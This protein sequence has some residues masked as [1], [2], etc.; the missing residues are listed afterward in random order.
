MKKEDQKNHIDYTPFKTHNGQGP[1]ELREPVPGY[2][3]RPGDAVLTPTKFGGVD[4]NSIIIFGRDRD[5]FRET[6]DG[7][8]EK[9][10]NDLFSIETVSGYSDYMGAGSI[11]IVVG[12]GAP[13]AVPG[14]GDYPNFLPP[15][16]TTRSDQRL[17]QIPLA[18]GEDHPGI[19]MDAARIYISQMSDV[20]EYFSIISTDSG[21]KI[22]R[23]PHSSIM[24]KSDRV[25]MHARRDIKIVAGGDKGPS[26]DSNGYSIK[27][28]G[29][30]HLIAGNGQYSNQQPIPVGYNLR[31]C[32]KD[33]VKNMND[34]LTVLD[35]FIV[36]QKEVNA[37]LADHFHATAAGPTTQDPLV[38]A[39]HAS[40]IWAAQEDQL[41]I[42]SI[43]AK[44]LLSL[45]SN[46][47]E[48]NG[49]NYI[50]SRYNTTT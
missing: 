21:T 40:F 12:R 45:V 14:V 37:V 49:V 35:N 28:N 19:V 47:L 48:P 26:I 13:Y 43:K 20:D 6:K 11:D 1:R 41:K 10:G 15:H 33:V 30:I 27:E 44:N 3:S 7:K 31:L 2:L 22:D 50:N 5:P 8:S 39:V 34:I 23:S 25:R 9:E 36:A 24:I 4:N 18:N 29:K 42:H 16:Y 38:Q 17:A 46:Y 32:L